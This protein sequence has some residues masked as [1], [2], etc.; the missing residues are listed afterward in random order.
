MGLCPLG[1]S[2]VCSAMGWNASGWARAGDT[3]ECDLAAGKAEKGKVSGTF[4]NRGIDAAMP[5][6]LAGGHRLICMRGA[7]ILQA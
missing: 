7:Y 1:F 5:A 6:G 3:A 4:G 2:R